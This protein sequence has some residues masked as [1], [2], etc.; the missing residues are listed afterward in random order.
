MLSSDKTVSID[1]S[2]SQ[3]SIIVFKIDAA[4]LK[5]PILYFLVPPTPGIFYD[6]VKKQI[7]QFAIN[8][9]LAMETTYGSSRPIRPW[10]FI[11]NC[12]HYRLNGTC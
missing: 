11:E 5:A 4:I 6:T 1:G 7:I 9:S 10:I 3:T 12:Q 8:P 2:V